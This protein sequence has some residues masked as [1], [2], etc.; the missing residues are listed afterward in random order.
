[1][2]FLLLKKGASSS[3]FLGLLGWLS[4]FTEQ[5]KSPPA[6]LGSLLPARDAVSL[7]HPAV[8]IF[9]FNYDGMCPLSISSLFSSL[10]KSMI[11][12]NFMKASILLYFS[13]VEL[14]TGK[15]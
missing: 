4:Y 1:M 13:V 8:F 14:V 10:G 6:V 5:S 12:Q 7:A 2:S 9:S 3:Q 11:T 15:A